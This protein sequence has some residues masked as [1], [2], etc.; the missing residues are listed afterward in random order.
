MPEN[1]LGLRPVRHKTCHIKRFPTGEKRE[2]VQ[3]GKGRLTMVNSLPSLQRERG[4]TPFRLGGGE[5]SE[6]G[7]YRSLKP[8][9]RK[10]GDK[11]PTREGNSR[12]GH[13]LSS[14]RKDNS[15]HVLFPS[16]ILGS[17]RRTGRDSTVLEREKGKGNSSRK[18]DV[19]KE[20]G[21]NFPLSITK[22]R[23]TYSCTKL[24]KGPETM[25]QILCG[26]QGYLAV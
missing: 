4:K 1:L 2:P 9:G 24:K 23:G 17:Q 7:A 26:D 13:N 3:G 15:E 22:K 10:S 19:L 6:H 18:L 12:V 14:Y 25:D 21:S 8:Q 5:A 20:K 16:N 11:T